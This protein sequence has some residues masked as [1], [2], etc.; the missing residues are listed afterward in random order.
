MSVGGNPVFGLCVRSKRLLAMMGSANKVPFYFAGY[1]AFDVE[2]AVL[3][4]RLTGIVITS[5]RPRN[6]V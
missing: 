6:F 5:H 3:I 1:N 4:P 2:W